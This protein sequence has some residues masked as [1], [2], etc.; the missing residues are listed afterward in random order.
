MDPTDSLSE[1]FAYLSVDTPA[2]TQAPRERDRFTDSDHEPL[3]TKLMKAFSA[4]RRLDEE[5]EFPVLLAMLTLGDKR[6]VTL[7]EEEAEE[8]LAS[9]PSI[10]PLLHEAWKEGSFKELRKLSELF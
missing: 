2:L 5:P 10:N 3:D 9:Y 8:L 1:G 7:T 4:F 6:L